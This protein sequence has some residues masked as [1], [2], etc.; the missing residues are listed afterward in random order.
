MEEHAAKRARIEPR[1]SAI[2]RQMRMHIK[3]L[4]DDELKGRRPGTSGEAIAARWPLLAADGC[5]SPPHQ[6]FIEPD[7]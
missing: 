4:A 6:P 5:A 2:E 3:F 7:Q 1:E